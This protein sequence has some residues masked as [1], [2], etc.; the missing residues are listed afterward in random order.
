MSSMTAP[1]MDG[2]PVKLTLRQ[3]HKG[4]RGEAFGDEIHSDV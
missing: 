4:E 3:L 2:M 1:V